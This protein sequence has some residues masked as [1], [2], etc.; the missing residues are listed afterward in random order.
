MS[1]VPLTVTTFSRRTDLTPGE[2]A[3]LGG[4]LGAEHVLGW[5]DAFERLGPTYVKVSDG[6]RTLAACPIYFHAGPKPFDL[7]LSY[8]PFAY[9]C[10]PAA[11]SAPLREAPAELFYPFVICGLRGNRSTLLLRDGLDPELRRRVMGAMLE[12]ARAVAEARGARLMTFPFLSCEEV[13]ELCE[14]SEDGIPAL[15]LVSPYLDVPASFEEYRHRFRKRIQLE[16]SA[17]ERAGYVVQRAVYP[18]FVDQLEE[19]QEMLLATYYPERGDLREFAKGNTETLRSLPVDKLFVLTAALNGRIDGVAS[20]LHFGDEMTSLYWGVRT[21]EKLPY[22][23]FNLAFYRAIEEAVKRG[24][25]RIHYGAG[26][27]RAKLLRGCRI[28]P[29]GTVLYPLAPGWEHLP[30]PL[31]EISSKRVQF[32]A[33]LVQRFGQWNDQVEEDLRLAIELFG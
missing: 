3:H 8:D 10:G 25:R 2:W 22:L 4:T 18:E 26:S 32:L 15:A 12:G 17:F 5:L 11:D 24:V 7:T 27:E 16:T 19:L 29:Q 20:F 13:R 1:S 23:Y 28:H 33:A 21:A 31:A 30:A 9:F 6:A 14:A